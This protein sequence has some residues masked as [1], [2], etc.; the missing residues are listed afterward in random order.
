MLKISTAVKK[1]LDTDDIAQ[2][3][4][5]RAL[6]NF[7]AYAEEIR[8][9]VEELTHKPVKKGSIVVALSRL[10]HPVI[11]KSR[12]KPKIK[13]CDI[14]VKSPLTDITFERTNISIEIISKLKSVERNRNSF[15]ALTHGIDEI[16]IIYSDELDSE[17]QKLT[18]KLEPKAKL[19]NLASITVQFSPKYIDTPNV[20]YTLLGSLALK[21]INIVEIISAYS[22]LTFVVNKNDL[23][24]CLETLQQFLM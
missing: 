23:S 1:I 24:L 4:M 11:K 2:E 6:L 3:A 13:L 17:I 14:S 8:P 12:L 19:R 15:F 7:S 22:E 20:I 5:E 18:K 10:E 21:R 9:K 16:T